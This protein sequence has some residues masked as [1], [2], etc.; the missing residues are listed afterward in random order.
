[1][2]SS[3]GFTSSTSILVVLSFIHVHEPAPIT[4]QITPLE[5]AISLV[6]WQPGCSH[7]F[8][9]ITA[10]LIAFLI[11]HCVIPVV[12]QDWGSLIANDCATAPRFKKY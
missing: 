4:K 7:V 5:L 8:S 3:I 6:R 9:Q 12:T 1:M 11:V 10:D 2:R